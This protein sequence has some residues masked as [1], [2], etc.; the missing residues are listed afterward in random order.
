MLMGL[1]SII[2]VDL[3]W[4]KFAELDTQLAVWIPAA[5]QAGRSRFDIGLQLATVVGSIFGLIVGFTLGGFTAVQHLVLRALLA[6]S[7]TMP[8]NIARFLDYCADR[9]FLRKVGGGYIFIHRLL[10]EH[11]A[12][13]YDEDTPMAETVAVRQ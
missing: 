5:Q 8:W 4:G 2:V 1:V 9:I 3:A 12:S 13:L 11:F 6:T 7:G 10:M